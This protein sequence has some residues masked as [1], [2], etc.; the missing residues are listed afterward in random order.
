[1]HKLVLL[2]A[3][4]D[5]CVGIYIEALLTIH[6]KKGMI[7]FIHPVFTGTA[8]RKIYAILIQTDLGVTSKTV[9]FKPVL[10]VVFCLWILTVTCGRQ[11]S[12]NFHKVLVFVTPQQLF[13]LVAF[14][15]QHATTKYLRQHFQ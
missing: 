5:L 13:Q 9:T 1:M 8:S 15:Y 12:L 10:M 3:S 11:D 14:L 6:Y 7:F 4:T 2:L